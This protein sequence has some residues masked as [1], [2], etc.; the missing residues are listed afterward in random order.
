MKTKQLPQGWK[1][2][3]LGD[4][5]FFKIVGSGLTKFNGEKDYLST[6]S[7]KENRI[8]K[9]EC[10][11]TFSNRPSRAN[12]QPTI[13]S[14]WFAKMKDTLKVYSFGNLNKEEINRYILS[15]VFAGIKVNEDLVSIKYLEYF[16]KSHEFNK[17]KNLLCSGAT[18]KAINNS[19]IKKIKLRLPPKAIQDKIVILLQKVDKIKQLK[20][21]SNR[22]TKDYVQKVFFDMFGH[23]F[24]KENKSEKIKLKEVIDIIVPTRDK[25][26]SFTGSIPWVTLPDLNDSIYISDSKYNLSL[27]EAKPTKTR[28]FPSETVILS[29]AG[30]L[31]KV[32]IA[33][34]EIFTNQ[35]FYGLVCDQKKILPEFLAC[36]LKIF[37]EKY[38]KGIGG[39]STITF[40]K[41]D[42]ALN[43][44]VILF[45]LPLQKK[46]ASIVKQVEKLKEYQEQS[47]QEINNLFNALMQ[48]AFRGEL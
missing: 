37:G 23:P 22:L 30:S 15:T 17:K 7:I 45:P 41:K 26:K 4:A 1:E 16:L 38:Y 35:Q 32:V 34:K 2:V 29:C 33:K 28:L 24:S 19:K 44:E 12:M 48:K 6:E 18:Q 8:K 39:T 25:P 27:E 9:I 20:E 21:D 36:Q 10:K 46:F 31:G 47:N 40:F 43:I 11:I 14:V 13:N 42:S 3:E 5:E